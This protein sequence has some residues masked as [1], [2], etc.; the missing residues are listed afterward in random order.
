[1]HARCKLEDVRLE[2]LGRSMGG[3]SREH[4]FHQEVMECTQAPMAF[5]ASGLVRLI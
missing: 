3:L 2:S 5:L 4:R 1:M